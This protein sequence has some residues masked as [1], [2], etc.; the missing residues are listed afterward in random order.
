[1]MTEAGVKMKW[2]L[3]YNIKYLKF[4]IVNQQIIRCLPQGWPNKTFSPA[5]DI[6]IEAGVLSSLYTYH[7][8]LFP[9]HCSLLFP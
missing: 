8:L 5:D 2:N 1:M 6:N 7:A 4:G 3:A 9:G